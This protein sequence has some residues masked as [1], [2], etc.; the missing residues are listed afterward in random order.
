LAGSGQN[1]L[2][3]VVITLYKNTS[4]SR[5]LDKSLIMPLELEG[6]LREESSVIT[7]SILI[8]SHNLSDYNYA[9]IPAFGRYYYITDI[10]S[11]RNGLWRVSLKCDVLMTYKSQIRSCKGIL[12]NTQSTGAT[13]YLTGEQYKRLVKTVT[14]IIDFPYGFNDNGE[15][16][17]IV[18]GGVGGVS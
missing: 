15:Y 2:F 17:L 7:P 8:S 14:D 10:T 5:K 13:D 1:P 4:D 11:V 9:H 6:V 3:D 16:I 12:R 18:A